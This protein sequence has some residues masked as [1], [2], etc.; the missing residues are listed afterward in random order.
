MNPDA[1]NNHAACPDAEGEVEQNMAV[2]VNEVI[3]G[4]IYCLQI[5]TAECYQRF[6]CLAFKLRYGIDK[7]TR[8]A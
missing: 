4:W 7:M 8:M 2:T 6:V 5:I 1:Q 3:D